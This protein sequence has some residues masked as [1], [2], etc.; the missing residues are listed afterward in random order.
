MRPDLQQELHRLI[1]TAH[2]E[3]A[4]PKAIEA[5]VRAALKE[6]DE[7]VAWCEVD[8]KL[9][10]GN[11]AACS[12]DPKILQ[13]MVHACKDPCHRKAVGYTGRA[14]D[15]NHPNYL[16]LE[17]ENHLYL[18]L[19]DP[20]VP[21]FKAASFRIF[22]DFVDRWI[23]ERPVI[24]HCNHGES[25]APSLAL[26]YMAKRLGTLPDTSYQL[27]AVAFRAMGFPYKPGEGIE[28]WLKDNWDAL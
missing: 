14:L 22:L 10:F 15:P 2:E 23:R 18:N 25:R 26:L 9:A 13:A 24:I 17:R 21:L 3:G 16:S 20:T 27:A 8:P 19:I 12:Y 7:L 1:V 28:K 4:T 5:E 11:M 6:R